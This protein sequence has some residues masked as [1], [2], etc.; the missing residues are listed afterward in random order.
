MS[1]DI[2]NNYVRQFSY[3]KSLADKAV[4]Q[5]NEQEVFIEPADG[6]NSIAVIMKH[7]AG[8][9][10]SRWTDIFN[11]DGEK[12]WRN[13]DQ[14]FEILNMNAQEL[15]AY[16]EKGW[17]VLLETLESLSDNDLERIIYIRNMGHTLQEAIVRQICHYPY[18]IGQIVFVAKLMKGEAFTSLS[19]PKN[20]SD[21][22]NA[23]KF[24]KEKSRK[25]FTDDL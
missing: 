16:W 6:S 22:Y 2:I 24:A 25:H 17:D 11:T 3:Y 7:I 12:P 1:K 15:Q 5:V 19:V 10:L 18:H 13:R 21:A 23:E 14:E 4:A 20:A 9:M 8:N